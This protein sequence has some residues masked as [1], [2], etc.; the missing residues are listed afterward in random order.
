MIK[1]YCD[2]CGNEGVASEYALPFGD[3]ITTYYSLR[4]NKEF[5]VGNEG[6]CPCKIHLGKH[7]AL[8]IKNFIKNEMIPN[9]KTYNEFL[10]DVLY[11]ERQKN[12]RT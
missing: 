8:R 10:L 2:I 11:K 1:Y 3:V 12:E 9:Y 6:F 7:C 4:E 5:V